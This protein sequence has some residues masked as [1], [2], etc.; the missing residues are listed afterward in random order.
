MPVKVKRKRKSSII[1]RTIRFTDELFEALN[2]AAEKKGIPVNRLVLQYC[3][4]SLDHILSEEGGKVSLQDYR[5][6][7]KKR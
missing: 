1:P 6:S 7:Q 5:P 2:A 4:Y 3:R